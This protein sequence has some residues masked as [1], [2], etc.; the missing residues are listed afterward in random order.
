LVIASETH[1]TTTAFA[2]KKGVW[3]I[4]FFLVLTDLTKIQAEFEL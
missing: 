4:F 3:T 2:L 1:Q